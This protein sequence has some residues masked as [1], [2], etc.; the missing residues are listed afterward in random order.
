[1]KDLNNLLDTFTRDND[2]ESRVKVNCPHCIHNEVCGRKESLLTTKRNVIKS[3]TY[4]LKE[5]EYGEDIKINI[6]CKNY[7]GEW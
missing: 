6:N 2:L 1:M 7:E 3:C 4:S 5:Q